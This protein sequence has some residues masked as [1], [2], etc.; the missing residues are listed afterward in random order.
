MNFRKPG[1]LAWMTAL[2]ALA[3]FGTPDSAAARGGGGGGGG[4]GGARGG[5][6]G[7]R[8]GSARAANLK[9]QNTKKKDPKELEAERERLRQLDYRD[10]DAGSDRGAR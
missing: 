2:L 5:G 6:G 1:T 9:R 4:G 7:T 10:V 3:F 8:G